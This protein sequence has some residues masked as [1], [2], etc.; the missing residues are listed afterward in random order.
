MADQPVKS[1]EELR[2]EAANKWR[3][4]GTARALKQSEIEQ[5][6]AAS[7]DVVSAPSVGTL[8]SHPAIVCS[9][10]GGSLFTV[11]RYGCVNGMRD[12]TTLSCQKCGTT[13]TWNWAEMSWLN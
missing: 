13:M 6:I 9:V 8:Y 3:A 10:C 11:R 7:P 5:E 4:N 12:K 2:Q 1:Y